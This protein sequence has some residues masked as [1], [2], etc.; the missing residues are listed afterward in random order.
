MIERH[1]I[2]GPEAAVRG[3]PWLAGTGRDADVVISSRVRLARNLAGRAFPV[4]STLAQRAEVLELCRAHLMSGLLDQPG[5]RMAWCDVHALAPLERSLLVERHLISKEHAKGKPLPAT[6]PAS[7]APA[8]AGT[9]PSAET[10]PD[11]RAFAVS[12]PDE[13]LSVM[14]NEEDHLRIQVLRS[15]LALTEAFESADRADDQIEG[16]LPGARAA[17]IGS[18]EPGVTPSQAPG[19]CYAFSSRFGYLTAC[20]T[21][22][23]CGARLS[24]MLHLPGLR[25]TG[26]I[27]KVKR[28]AKDLNLA[29]RGYYG[30][31]SEATGDLYQVSNQSTFG[32]PE[33]AVLHEIERE[34]IPDI[35]RYE[36][37]A[38]AT[39][40]GKR[41][42]LL[43]DQVYRALALLQSARLVTPE[44]ALTN[45]SLVR[46]GIATGL[47]PL[48]DA[49][50][51][52]LF[53]LTQPAH[54]QRVVG[55]ELDQQRRREARADLLRARLTIQ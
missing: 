51:T 31:G 36:R 40:A 5:R 37:D 32:R 38:R 50:V 9:P 7:A 35:V 6:V 46:L 23:G 47:V 16:T 24:V 2:I 18:A 21:N 8:G 39:L 17:A 1:Q 54:L 33:R 52:Q 53:L 49:D 28:A 44:E 13:S 11:P 43:E 12:L 14:V 42:R 48:V 19:L 4:R 25:L 15:G 22:V 55:R 3:A 20:P 10:L 41:R 30:E 34:I 29:L 45:L 27:E 26:E